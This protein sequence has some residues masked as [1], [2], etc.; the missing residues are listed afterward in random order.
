MWPIWTCIWGMVGRI[1]TEDHYALLHT[2]HTSC[3]PQGL[4][5]DFLS[6]PHFKSMETIDP[7]GMANLNPR[8]M[9]GRIYVGDHQTLLYILNI[10]VVVLVVSDKDLLGF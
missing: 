10:K 1:Y 7:Q 6:F 3:G 5:D 9:V 8:G 4:R 2:M